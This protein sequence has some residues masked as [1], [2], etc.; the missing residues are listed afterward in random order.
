MTAQQRRLRPIGFWSYARQDD[1]ASDGRLSQLR[2]QL[3]RELQQVYG[4]DPIQLW[5]DVAA[6]P[7][8][9]EWEKAIDDAIAQST[10]LIPIITPAFVESEFCC[11]EVAK[12]FDREAEINA[13]HPELKGSRRI[14]PIVYIGADDSDPFD[15]VTVA[16][17]RELQFVDFRQ[18]REDDDPHQIRRAVVRLAAEIARLLKVK[19]AP[20]PTPEELEELRRREAEKALKEEQR[21]RAEE[22]EARHKAEEE[23]LEKERLE[24][25]RLEENRQRAEAERQQLEERQ[26]QREAERAAR[27]AARKEW[28]RRTK[29][30]LASVLGA[31]SGR[32]AKALAGLGVLGTVVLFAALSLNGE[33]TSKVETGITTVDAGLGQ[34]KA[35]PDDVGTEARTLIGTWSLEGVP[36]VKANAENGRQQLEWAPITG[37]KVNGVKV[38][39]SD[40]PNAEGWFQIDG[41][42]WRIRDG[43]L[44]LSAEGGADTSATVLNRCSG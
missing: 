2:G 19:V 42:Y 27:I 36:C 33:Q 26:K 13:A 38:K 21:K 18:L 10:F 1:E 5:Q 44:H 6:I 41:L 22:E 34:P 28:Q 29:E 3:A 4:R 11:R 15:P 40:S 30:R 9:A 8:G 24:R 43:Q 23:R 17:L 25:E 7:P 32:A 20:A 35:A 37:W 16:R 14:F 31:F 39:G 12:F